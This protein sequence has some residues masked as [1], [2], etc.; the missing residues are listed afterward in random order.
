MIVTLL[1]DFGL[2]D[3]YVGVMKGVLLSVDARIRVVDLTHEIVPGGIDAGA[4]ALLSAYSYFPAGTVHVAVVDP[5]VGSETRAIV[6]A[7]AGQYFVG[8]DNGLFSY[9]LEVEPQA[10]IRAI[11]AERFPR[12][13]LSDTFHGRDLFAPVGAAVGTGLAPDRLGPLWP[14][15]VRLPPLQPRRDARGALIG[16]VLH[17]DRFGNCVTSIGRND[18]AAGSGE[19]RLTVGGQELHEVRRHYGG[20]APGTA[21][22][23]WGSS[24]LLEISVNGGSAAALLGVETGAV[25]EVVGG[26]EDHSVSSEVKG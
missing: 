9:L 21:F 25:V 2:A 11:G 7:A 15:P 23:I 4:F 19:L 10:T 16:R 5:G 26:G 20:A 24:E 3:H 12:L 18:L 8:P 1:T 6:V 13:P 17:V 22:L 14:E